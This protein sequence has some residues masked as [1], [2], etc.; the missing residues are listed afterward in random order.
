MKF[1]EVEAKE[2]LAAKMQWTW[3]CGWTGVNK[4]QVKTVQPVR[5]V[6]TTIKR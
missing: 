4:V 6:R 2:N 1:F 3:A 5:T